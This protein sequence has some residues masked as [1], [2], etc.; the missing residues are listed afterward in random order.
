V[1]GLGLF[2]FSDLY[3]LDWVLLTGDMHFLCLSYP[4]SILLDR[5]LCPLIQVCCL[6]F[7]LC[8]SVPKFN[9]FD[10]TTYPLISTLIEQD[11]LSLMSW[12]APQWLLG[13]CRFTNWLHSNLEQE[14]PKEVIRTFSA[15]MK[16]ISPIAMK[17]SLVLESW[18]EFCDRA[19]RSWDSTDS[20][21]SK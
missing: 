13:S 12:F 11:L 4:T 2:D 17:K 6:A 5:L 18:E 1:S 19:Y 21:P 20:H 16:F 14:V 9:I 3:G 8:S 15:G 10:H 7:T